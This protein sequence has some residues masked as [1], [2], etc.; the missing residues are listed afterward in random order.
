VREEDINRL[1]R[2]TE[3]LLMDV[4]GVLTDGSIFWI[5]LADGTF[6][7]AKA[8]D[9]TDGAGIALGHRAGLRTGIITGRD[10]PAVAHRAKELS[11]PLVLQGVHDKGEALAQVCISARLGADRI[12]FVGD[13]VVD[14]PILTRVGFPVAVR[15]A[16]PEV[17]ARASYVTTATGG[18]GAIREVVELILKAQN[19]WEGLMESF[20][21]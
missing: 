3:L 13:D 18:H 16:R 21:E 14:L 12:C 7:E 4:D 19:K 15:N 17:L 20:L 1:A 10:S 8:F 6:T 11:I 2:Q 5:S 9:V